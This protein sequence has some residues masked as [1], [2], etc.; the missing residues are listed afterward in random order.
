MS[1][2]DKQTGGEHYKNMAVQPMEFSLKN[3]LDAAQHTAIK[4]ICRH[5]QKNGREDL[6][7]AKHCIDMLIEHYYGVEEIT[8]S[9]VPY[10]VEFEEMRR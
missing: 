10:T 5:K 4:Y 6:E 1:A 7:K 9:G 8:V 2:W 3:N